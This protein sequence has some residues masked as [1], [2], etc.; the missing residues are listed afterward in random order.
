MPSKLTKRINT[1]NIFCLGCLPIG[2]VCWLDKA[3][4]ERGI[5]F[6][7]TQVVLRMLSE[8]PQVV[9]V[10]Q[11]N[12]AMVWDDCMAIIGFGLQNVCLQ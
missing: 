9:L 6:I 2:N 4:G 11:E 7:I 10:T 1:L 12:V 5:N 3:A 8:V